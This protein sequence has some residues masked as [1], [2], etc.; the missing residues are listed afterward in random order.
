MNE[1]KLTYLLKLNH[2]DI[3][4]T[5]NFIYYSFVNNVV[6]KNKISQQPIRYK[7]LSDNGLRKKLNTNSEL[8]RIIKCSGDGGGS[9]LTFLYCA[10]LYLDDCEFIRRHNINPLFLFV[11][12]TSS[13]MVKSIYYL[14]SDEQLSTILS[15]TNYGS[16]SDEIDDAEL[17]AANSANSLS[18]EEW[19]RIELSFRLSKL[20]AAIQAM[21][22]MLDIPGYSVKPN[23]THSYSVSAL[24]IVIFEYLDLKRDDYYVNKGFSYESVLKQVKNYDSESIFFSIGDEIFD[25]AQLII[26]FIIAGAISNKD[27]LSARRELIKNSI[28]R[29]SGGE[30]VDE[31]NSHADK[32]RELVEY[33]EL[34]IQHMDQVIFHKA[35]SRIWYV[36]MKSYALANDMLFQFFSIAALVLI[37]PGELKGVIKRAKVA[38]N[39]KTSANRKKRNQLNVSISSDILDSFR[40]ICKN[41]NIKQSE[42]VEDAIKLYISTKCNR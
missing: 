39:N 4:R 18:G 35:A 12:P 5:I 32:I 23:L 14:E 21:H 2:Q 15:L 6:V 41:N 34:F 3:K 38:M 24:L 20:A 40:L 19:E 27:A 26:D 37:K 9:T 22:S 36:K 28:T 17:K 13:V 11:P 30:I 33:G 10:L 7:T 8:K 42:F 31:I 29:F 16:L 1:N 25:K